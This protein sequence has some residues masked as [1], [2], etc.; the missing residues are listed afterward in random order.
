MTMTPVD[1]RCC[2][3]LV[4]TKANGRAAADYRQAWLQALESAGLKDALAQTRTF[5]ASEPSP[6]GARVAPDDGESP[7]PDQSG[8]PDEHRRQGQPAAGDPPMTAVP[9]ARGAAVAAGRSAAPDAECTAPTSCQPPEVAESP[10][11]SLM[12]Q[13]ATRFSRGN[14]TERVPLSTPPDGTPRRD[15]QSWRPQHVLALPAS[16]GGV[17]LWVRD[18]S[19]N[20]AQMQM[21]LADLRRMLPEREP[22]PI[23]HAYLN[24]QPVAATGEHGKPRG[25]KPWRSI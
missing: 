21:L 25:E 12:A 17:E 10:V 2:A 1:S 8:N 4:P 5:V 11:A 14:G 20:G 3:E 6:A 22:Y 15:A 24:G 7:A 19:L 13:T 18:A 9:P 16:D 23:T